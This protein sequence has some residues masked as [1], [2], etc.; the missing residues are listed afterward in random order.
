[1]LAL[2]LA[3]LF[4]AQDTPPPPGAIAVD[5]LVVEAYR[6]KPPPIPPT[7]AIVAQ[8]NQL[9][10]DQ[11]DRVVCL[12]KAPLGTRIPNNYCATL[13]KWYDFQADRSVDKLLA[14][15]SSGGGA[16]GGV[17]TG[18]PYELVDVI[19]ARYRNPTTRAQAEA[20]SRLRA[21]AE[22]EAARQPASPA[23]KP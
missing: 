6:K 11:P 20:R 9:V 4:A 22:V 14:A 3:A 10:K 21:A 5:P 1:M 18:P 12:R 19:R 2:A 7:Q 8:L 13:R 23:S 16:S 15:N 17:I